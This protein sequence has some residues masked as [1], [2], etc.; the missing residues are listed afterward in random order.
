MTEPAPRIRRRARRATTIVVALAA[1]MTGIVGLGPG[2][3]EGAVGAVSDSDWLGIVNTYRAMSGLGPVTANAAW[4]SEAA[5]HSCYMLFNGIAHDEVPGLRGYTPGGDTAGNSGNVAVSS[6]VTATAR[7]HIDLWMTGPFHAIGILRHN[8]ASAG[9]GMCALADTPT[10]WHSGGTLDVIRGI[11]FTRARPTTPIVFPG[12]GQTVPLN[13]FITEFPNPVTLCGWTGSAG[14]PLIAM[15][16]NDVSSASATLTGPNGPLQTCVLHEGNTKS[17]AT[18][19]AILGG[20]NA[21]V[22]MPRDILAN[23]T[24]TVNVTSTGGNASWSFK[25]NAGGPLAFQS[26]QTEPTAGGGAFEPVPPFRL[27]DTREPGGPSRLRARTVTRIRVGDAGITAVSANFT[28]ANPAGPGFVTAYDCTATPPT[29][30]TINVRPGRNVS[31]QAI[32][33]LADGFLCLYTIV[34]TDIVIDVNGY[35]RETGADARFTPITPLRLLD[36]RDPG[37]TSLRPLVEQRVQVTGIGG[38]APADA[39]AVTLNVTAV[40]PSQPGWLLASDCNPTDSSSLN[41]LAGENRPNSVVVPLDDA[42]GICLKAR[43]QTDA[44]VDIT[45]YFTDGNALDFVPLSP[46]RLLDTRESGGV[47]NPFTGGA[48]IPAG[49]VVRLDLAGK[50]GVPGDAKAVSINVT[51]TDTI[52]STFITAYPCGTRPPTSNVNLR[53]DQVVTAN[54]AVVKLSA[55]GDLCLFVRQATHVIVDI[56]GVFN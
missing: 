11:D 56:N 51:A 29:V 46:L 42:G 13:A 55:D 9:F 40:G 31:N 17:D 18:A 27:V 45:G 43:S 41:F 36:T 54:G 35:F 10:P 5:A 48:R 23:G 49:G 6:A 20:D 50:R 24:Y 16:P 19:A 3:G 39:T 7:N 28:A 15:M 32:A 52:D 8:L 22:I 14:L 26:P 4:S 34:D 21:V 44:I 53:T 47:L 25:V 12:D 38:S 37:E 30:S 2:T 33:P 1:A